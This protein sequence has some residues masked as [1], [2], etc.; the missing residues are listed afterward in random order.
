MIL[1]MYPVL[2]RIG[3]LEI[4]SF[5]VMVALGAL[6]GILLIRREL[7]RS[8][9]DSVKGTDAALVGVLGGL[10]GAKLLYVAE[11][12]AEPLAETLLSRGGMSWFGGF[13]G[14]V[15]AG[16]AWIVWQRLPLMTVLS[17]AAPA[18]ALGHA[19]GRIGCFLVGDD[20]GRPTS[21]P[22]AIAFPEGLP[23]TLDRVHP[24]QLYE[25]AFL[26]AFTYL[27]VRLRKRRVADQA[28]FGI[29]LVGAG[30]LRFLIEI[31][32]V[33]VRVLFGLTTA[34]LFSIV[35]VALGVALLVRR[36]PA[37][38]VEVVQPKAPGRRKRH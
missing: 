27:L 17:A 6:L 15:L 14:G 11:H 7:E 31:V 36:A 13:T 34:Q 30:T 9:V 19:V 33:N 37:E 3:S 10:A 18:L 38:V 24:T 2:F 28:V 8:G 20:Y 1:S 32:R 35:V 4:T 16:I 23:P 26:F 25:A 22:W 12:W 21:L 5:G 29:Y